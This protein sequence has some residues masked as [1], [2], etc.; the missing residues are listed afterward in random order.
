MSPSERTP[1]NPL[2]KETIH[3]YSRRAFWHDYASPCFYHITLRKAPQTCIFSRVEINGFDIKGVPF[4][5]LILSDFGRKIQW[6]IQKYRKVYKEAA[7]ERYIIMPDH[8]H[9]ILNVKERFEPGIG[10]IIR[11]FKS[12]CT[13]RYKKWLIENNR[14]IEENASVFEENYNDKILLR[15]GQLKNWVNYIFDNPRRYLIKKTNP[16]LFNSNLRV[17]I[18]GKEYAAY[19]NILLLGMPDKSAV[20]VSRR[21]SPEVLKEK[22]SEWER[23]AHNGGVLVSPFISQREKE[24]MWESVEKGVNLII[25]KNIPFMEKEK[26]SKRFFNL[27]AEG[28]LLYITP[29]EKDERFVEISRKLCNAMN[30]F[31]I[32]IAEL[33]QM[34][35]WR[36]ERR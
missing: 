23:I 10:K 8:I 31:S 32:R 5:K 34:P 1:I 13:K 11:D 21:Y 12:D 33:T 16:D 17:M 15:A 35:E 25:I 24:V 2:Y 36:K 29:V 27:C 26:P 9:F 18:N 28:R 14:Q 22:L 4:P 30:D 3:S 6:L 20:K 7:I 19:G